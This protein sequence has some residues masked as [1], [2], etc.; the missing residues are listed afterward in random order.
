M[1]CMGIKQL[2][3]KSFPSQYGLI[4]E[5]TTLDAPENPSALNMGSRLLLWPL[6]AE[7]CGYFLILALLLTHSSYSPSP[8]SL[9]LSW[10][11]IFVDQSP[12][13]GF[14]SNVIFSERPSIAFWEGQNNAYPK[15]RLLPS[16]W[17][18]GLCDLTWKERLSKNESVFWDMKTILDHQSDPKITARKRRRWKNRNQGWRCH[19]GAE[20]GEMQ[21]HKCK[22][23]RWPPG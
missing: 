2:P 9:G 13:L 14:I 11:S 22:A 17:K 3:E 18:L 4:R 23:I 6:N 5:K 7:S 20:V 16:L 8:E 19:N 10:P 21:T 12:R 15:R 1:N